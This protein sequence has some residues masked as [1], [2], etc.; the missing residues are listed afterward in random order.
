[1]RTQQQSLLANLSASIDTALEAHFPD[2]DQPQLAAC[3]RHA[4]F[5]GGRRMRPT[6]CMLAAHALGMNTRAALPIA[7]AIEYLHTASLIYDD[8]PA[9]DD[10]PNRRGAPSAH[11]KFGQG[12]AL[13]AGLALVSHAMVLLAPSTV[14]V[15]AAGEC[16]ATMSAGQAID[17]QGGTRDAAHYQKTTALFRLAV[18][19]PALAFCA[20]EAKARALA[21]FGESLGRAYQFMDDADDEGA[22]ELRAAAREHLAIAL[23][24]LET[25][26]APMLAAYAQTLLQP[27]LA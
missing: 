3:M 22:E 20:E 27:V 5:S 19:A 14:L 16:V 15:R 9:M 4:V 11:A 12:V 1:M 21:E 7:A 13:L 8:L 25:L 2:C 6:L 18:S 17:L 24:A 26:Q 10:S 23:A